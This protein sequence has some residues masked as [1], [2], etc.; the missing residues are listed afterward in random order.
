V[1][2]QDL[3]HERQE[4]CQGVIGLETAACDSV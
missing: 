4:R 1:R 2:R 3:F